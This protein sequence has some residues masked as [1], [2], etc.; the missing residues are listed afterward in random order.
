MTAPQVVFLIIALVTIFSAIM[1][2]SIKNL[3]HAA[4]WLILSLVRCSCVFCVVRSELFCSGPITRLYWRN[5]NINH[6]RNHVNP[7]YYD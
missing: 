2:V 5:C 4:L 6:F 7:P 3:F 1:V